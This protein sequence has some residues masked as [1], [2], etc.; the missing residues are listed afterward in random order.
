MGSSP[1]ASIFFGLKYGLCGTF[2]L[3][4]DAYPELKPEIVIKAVNG[5]EATGISV[6]FRENVS[7]VRYPNNP[8]ATVEES[9]NKIIPLVEMART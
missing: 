5:G 7:I 9:I 6:K 8:D 3:N 2:E 4:N 1:I